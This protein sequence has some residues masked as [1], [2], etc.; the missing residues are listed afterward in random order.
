MFSQIAK[1]FKPAR[2][3]NRNTAAG[4]APSKPKYT[5]HSKQIEWQP[6]DVNK[7]TITSNRVR[8]IEASMVKDARSEFAAVMNELK[9]SQ[10]AR[11]SETSN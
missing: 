9:S 11:K 8:E 3:N 2:N 7:L 1:L 6:L 10:R 4:Q 5:A